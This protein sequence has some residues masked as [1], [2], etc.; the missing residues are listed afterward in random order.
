M[1]RRVRCRGSAW[2]IGGR[3]R[4]LRYDRLYGRWMFAPGWS[5]FGE[6]N[7]IDFGTRNVNFPSTGMVPGLGA[8]GARADTNAIRL[9]AQEAIIG[10]NYKFNWASPVVAK[11]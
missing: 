10:V 2:R 3:I 6:Y 9:T 11:D 4:K 1:D 5:V 7:Y 8:V